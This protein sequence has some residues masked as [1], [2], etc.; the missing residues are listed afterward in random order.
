MVMYHVH[1]LAHYHY[2]LQSLTEYPSI[3]LP[4]F[5]SV[6][7]SAVMLHNNELA[8]QYNGLK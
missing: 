7:L 4:K 8:T 3:F 5:L 2:I 1:V 6:Q